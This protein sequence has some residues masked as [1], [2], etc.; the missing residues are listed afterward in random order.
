MFLLLQDDVSAFSLINT[1]NTKTYQFVVLV[2]WPRRPD[3][4]MAPQEPDNFLIFSKT[5]GYRHDSIAA[6]VSA[7][8]R[9]IGEIGDFTFTSSEDATLFTPLNLSMYRVII[10]LHSSG[11]FLSDNQLSALQEFVRSGG[12]VFSIHGAAAGMP[13]SEWYRKLIGAHFDMHPEPEPGSLQSVNGL[14]PINCTT[15]LDGLPEK[16]MDEWYNFTSHPSENDNLEILLA[17]NTKTFKGGKHGAHHP[18]AWCQEFEG[19][20]SA[21]IALGH[22]STAWESKWFT[23]WV[24][25]GLLWAAGR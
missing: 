21:Y 8:K 20:K 15:G 14:H 10:L 7:L 6:G 9:L 25:R 13:S 19:G 18:L 12:G 23:G 3:T 4:T 22:F 5:A 16:W 11:D 24:G 17:G 1:S 2:S